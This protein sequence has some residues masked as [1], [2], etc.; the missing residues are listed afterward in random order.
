M[1]VSTHLRNKSI[2]TNDKDC[3]FHVCDYNPPKKY[4]TF[5]ELQQCN[6][7]LNFVIPS[8]AECN[9]IIVPCSVWHTMRM[10]KKWY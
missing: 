5:A 7:Y 4:I 8:A 10:Y 3:S 1:K 2:F 6:Y 9:T